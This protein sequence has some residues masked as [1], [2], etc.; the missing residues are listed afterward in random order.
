MRAGRRS[1]VAPALEIFRQER[2]LLLDTLLLGVVGALAAQVFMYLLRGA[3][4]LFLHFIAGYRPPSAPSDNPVLPQWIGA[5]GLWLIPL[6][7]TLGGLISGILV[8]TLAPEAEGHGTDTVVTA[9]HRAGGAIRARV[10]PL[11]MIASAITIGS[12]GSAGREGPTALIA[13]GVGAT[14]AS[15]THRAEADR[16]LLGLIGMA[17]GL[18][19]I[20]RSPIGTALFAVEV[21]YSGMQFEAG[22][23]LY[24]MI[25]S[26]VAYA[27]NGVFSGW[28]PLFRVP[29][30]LAT[31][32]FMPIVWYVVLGVVAGIVGAILPTVFYSVRDL[33][34]AIPI[35]NILKPALGGLGV[36]VLALWLPQVLAGGYGWIQ[37]AIDG[38]M[39]LSLLAALAVA[40]IVALSLTVSS[41]GSGGV[42]APSLFVGAMVGGLLAAVLHATPAPLVIIGMAAV[43]GAAARVPLATLLMVTEMTGGYRL[44]VPAALTVALSYLVQE[45]LTARAKY[46]SLYEGQVPGEADSPAHQADY[47]TIAKRLLEQRGTRVPQS[48]GHLRLQVLLG[49]GIPIDLP[50]GKQ[51]L[52]RTVADGSSASGKNI[53]A[54]QSDL[55]GKEV[56]IAA[57]F[58][59][60]HTLLVHGDLVLEPNDR[61]LLIAAPE[62]LEAIAPMFGAPAAPE[63][64]SRPERSD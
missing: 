8:Y 53:D 43:F 42:F 3:E 58:R 7:T 62:K 64:G 40:K 1:F 23:L 6:S 20:F 12:G 27:V 55:T 28:A 9:F 37:I 4:I 52:L 19:A 41:G 26:I 51:L 25:A 44:L 24:T 14:Y 57:V 34:R 21:L 36:G 60:Q 47:L 31:P 35:P 32:G 46:P 2:R 10:A 13:A 29:Q 49:G 5:H 59:A 50:D 15:L 30:N 39:A 17:A 61:L 18:A 33:F 56:E 48:F 16:R 38:R 54:L 45:I 22:A 11:K 63:R